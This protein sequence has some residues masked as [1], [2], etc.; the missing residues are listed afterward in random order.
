MGGCHPKQNDLG[1]GGP[2][3]GATSPLLG[4]TSLLLGAT[5]PLLGATS[6]L[7]GATSPLLGADAVRLLGASDPPRGPGAG[8]GKSGVGNVAVGFC[9]AIGQR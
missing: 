1:N 4:A 9:F 2:L 6:P 7:L 8:E 3:L 5:S